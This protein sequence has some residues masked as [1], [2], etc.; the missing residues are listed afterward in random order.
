M[1]KMNKQK[2]II[3]DLDQTLCNSTEILE[4]YVL[5]R[6]VIDW[7]GYYENIDQ[8]TVNE[9]VAGLLER[10]CIDSDKI[11]FLTARSDVSRD[12]TTSWL[13][14]HFCDCFGTCEYCELLMRPEGIKKDSYL[15]KKEIYEKQVKGKYDVE[16]VID[17]DKS[18]IDMFEAEGLNCLHVRQKVQY[19]D[20]AEVTK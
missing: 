14:E 17:D 19:T 18:V 3:V 1:G 11:F 5:N 7:A 13:Q 8:C 15:M 16:F 6:E 2:C 9:W 12:K 10:H 20:Y 4:K